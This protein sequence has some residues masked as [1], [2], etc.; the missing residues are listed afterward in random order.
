MVFKK[1]FFI[2]PLF[3]ISFS[4]LAYSQTIYKWVDDQG[5]THFT[6]RYDKIPPEYRDQVQEP[7]RAEEPDKTRETQRKKE[8]VSP[9]V[10]APIEERPE[11]KTAPS[12]PRR[13]ETLRK[14]EKE[15]RPK[16][17]F[18]GRYWITDLTAKARVTE[19]GIG[20]E[21]DFKADLGL[22][23]ENFP[24][25]RFTWYTGPNSKL[26]LVYTQVAYSGDKNMERTI[27]FAGSTYPIGTRVI[28]DLDVKYLGLGWIWQFINIA[29]GTVKFGTLIEAKGLFVETSLEAPNL[30]PPIKESVRF[31]VGIPTIGIALDGNPHKVVTVF[32]EVS[33]LYAGMYGYFLDGEVGVKI[34]PI[35]NVSVVGGYRI[36]DFKAEYNP[37]F[38]K[39]KIS[40][41][42]VGATLRF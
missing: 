1:S 12:L 25:V 13:E 10:I 41:P 30:I 9:P 3:I 32:A 11:V 38:G 36:L 26:R 35:R 19:S 39:A 8:S 31:R 40:G 6:T 14:A 37:D 15:T 21:I 18:E 23:D 27:D 42:F 7:E 4:Y 34:I 5:N 28:T 20:T 33:G 16:I 2:I 24:D 22:K 29:N 17:E